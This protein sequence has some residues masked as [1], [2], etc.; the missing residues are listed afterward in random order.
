V[1][2]INGLCRAGLAVVQHPPPAVEFAWDNIFSVQQLSR[3]FQLQHIVCFWAIIA[4]AML[5]KVFGTVS[6]NCHNSLAGV[7]VYVR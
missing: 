4:N 3:H 2:L 6:E 5:D 1:T 7:V